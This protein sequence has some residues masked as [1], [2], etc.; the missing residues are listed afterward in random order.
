MMSRQGQPLIPVITTSTVR[1]NGLSSAEVRMPALHI[2]K[3]HV[4]H[5]T[6]IILVVT[7]GR[8]V[9]LWWDDSGTMHRLPQ[10]AGQHLFIP[11]LVPHAAINPGRVETVG[12]EIRSSRD[13]NTDNELLPELDPH[14]ATAMTAIEA[15]A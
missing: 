12:V 6:D 11:R 2:S 14:V 9:T 4:H 5:H 13:F 15:A 3:A 7:T 8:A 10:H 1:G